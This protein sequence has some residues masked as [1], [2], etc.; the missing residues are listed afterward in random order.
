MEAARSVSTNSQVTVRLIASWNFSKI[1]QTE[2]PRSWR[3]YLTVCH[4]YS[5]SPQRSCKTRRRL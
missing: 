2:L 3:H 4:S 5:S 1:S